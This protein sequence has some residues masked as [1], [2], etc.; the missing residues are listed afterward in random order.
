MSQLRFV[1]IGANLL[2]DR[3][4]KGVYHEKPRH[5]PDFDQVV[6]RAAKVGVRHII[7]TAGTIEESANAVQQ[8]RKLRQA[9]QST[10][11]HFSCTVGVHPTRCLQEFVQGEDDDDGKDDEARLQRL[12]EI[13]KD[14]MTD[15]SVVAIGEIGLDYDRLQFTPKDVQIKYFIRQLQV[16]AADTGLPLFLHNRSVG[17]DLYDLLKEHQDCWTR[18]GVVHS[19][20]DSHDLAMKFVNDLGLYIGLNGCSLR[21]GTNLQVAK[22]LPLDKVLLETDCPYCEVK[23]THAGFHHVKTTFPTKQEKKFEKGVMVKGRCEPCQIIQ[24]AEVLAGVKEIPLQEV[25]DQCFENSLKLY[26]WDA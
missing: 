26:G 25:A 21:E 14:G 6:E 8:V 7:M 18:G 23:R 3:F 20:D 15:Q 17:S 11:I 5:E 1:D 12:L 19:F 22:E 4:T 2:D 9:Q 16:L 24:V 10:G 13:A